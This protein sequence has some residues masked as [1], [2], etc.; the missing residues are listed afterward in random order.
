MKTLVIVTPISYKQPQEIL[1]TAIRK[2]IDMLGMA[3]LE[4]CALEE[5]CNTAL[6]FDCIFSYNVKQ[7]V[8]ETLKNLSYISLFIEYDNDAPLNFVTLNI[9]TD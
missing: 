7:K 5:N 2:T 6:S 9:A 4:Y 8:T 3:S 1:C